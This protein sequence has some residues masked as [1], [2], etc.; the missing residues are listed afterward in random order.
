MKD[1]LI[2]IWNKFLSTIN[3]ISLL[4]TL[5]MLPLC[6]GYIIYYMFVDCIPAR[7]ILGCVALWVMI[8]SN[9]K[10]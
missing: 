5:F 10:L 6:L 7:A 9:K 3:G 8:D 1:K 4:T 2:K